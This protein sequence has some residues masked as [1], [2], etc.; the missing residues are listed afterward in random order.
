MQAGA[1][2]LSTM[3]SPP[4]VSVLDRYRIFGVKKMPDWLYAGW[5]IHSAL[6]AG[7]TG[8]HRAGRAFAGAAELSCTASAQLM[9]SSLLVRHRVA[10]P[11]GSCWA[12]FFT[13]A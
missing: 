13:W 10:F 3:H 11:G 4:R 7:S 12:F 1:S 2:Q 9:Q 6:V 8:L 5:R